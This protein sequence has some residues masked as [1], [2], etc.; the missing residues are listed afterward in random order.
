MSEDGL[1]SAIF[2]AM[3][4]IILAGLML[5]FLLGRKAADR[6]GWSGN[7]RTAMGVIVGAL[8]I[9]GGLL[10]VIATFYESSWDPPP[11]V[12]FNA[13]PGFSHTWVIVLED[14]SAA[15]QLVW[16]GIEMPFFG[17]KTVIDVPPSGIVRVKKLD[18]LS[19]RVDI[20]AQWS[21]G[22]ASTGQGGGPAPKSSGAISFSSFNKVTSAGEALPDPP[23]GDKEALGSYIAARENAPK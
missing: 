15:R 2:A 7:K 10:A 8:G 6:I 11:Q 20:N 1:A 16:Q 9:G 17:K 23:F 4:L 21:D 18:G 22:S 5:G 13:P 12:T 3:I 14:P 19:G